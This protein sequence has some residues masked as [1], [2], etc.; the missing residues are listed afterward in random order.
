MNRV[1]SNDG[2][3]IAYERN[4]N[5]P[6]VILVGGATVARSENTPLACFTGG[7]ALTRTGDAAL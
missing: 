7:Y 5:G 6:A 1:T 3:S 2:T 4:G